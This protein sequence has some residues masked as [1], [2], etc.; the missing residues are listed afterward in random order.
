M[1]TKLSSI[2]LFGL[3]G[4]IVDVEV[5]I[6]SGMPSF[7]IVGLP[8][9]AVKESK[10]RVRA[11]IKNCGYSLPIR[12]ILVNLA[13]ADI[14][15]EGAVFDVPILLGVL[16][17]SLLETLNFKDC[18][19]CGE[20]SLTGK[21]R[22]VR[23]VLPTAI[24]AME[25]GFKKIFVPY[26]NANEAAI[27]EGIEVYPIRHINDIILHLKNE[28]PIPVHIRNEEKIEEEKY[29]STLDFIDVCGQD[30]AKRA[31]EIAAAGGHNI[32]FVGSPGSGKSMIAKRIPTI[33]PDMTVS[34]QI[35]TTKIHSI[36]GTLDNTEGLISERPFRSPHHTISRI[37]LAGGGRVASPGELS[38]AHNGVLFL[39]EL[40]EFPKNILEVLRQPLEDGTVTIARATGT[41]TFPCEIMLVGAMN[42][43]R[44]GYHGHPTKECTCSANS[45][46]E[47][48]SKISG[49]LLDR[50][51]LQISVPPV[52]YEEL[53]G[54]GNSSSKEI[55]ER[56]QRARAIQQKRFEDKPFKC[57]ARMDS[58]TSKKHCM[59][60]N[61]GEEFLKDAFDRFQMT[62]RAYEKVLR[63]ARTIADLDGAEN[64]QVF[65]LA[66]AVQYRDLDKG[67][68]KKNSF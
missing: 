35:E 33:L 23:G 68:N 60:T 20:L 62:A 46:R 63:I 22:A 31:I 10:D 17:A 4:Y 41:I 26:E 61:I 34:E 25:S 59:I 64:I 52:L 21:V 27:V 19:F 37:G 39:D 28:V 12:K 13:P 14:K 9:A 45:V 65:H 67:L 57:N 15:K 50:F 32:L 40:A 36:A 44:C 48:S 49:P 5:D 1:V 29:K 8:D 7:D 66:E 24:T 2:G 43:C 47:Y 6:T 30:F 16:K 42:P 55:K 51:D 56:V 18:I 54:K 58:Q 11:A 3:S 38:L 53:R